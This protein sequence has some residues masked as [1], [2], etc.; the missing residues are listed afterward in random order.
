MEL[1]LQAAVEI[2]PESAIAF[3]SPVGSAMTASLDPDKLLILIS[4]S[5]RALRKSE[6]HPVD[7]G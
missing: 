6:R 4:E 2:E 3:D 5:V 1:Q 7:A